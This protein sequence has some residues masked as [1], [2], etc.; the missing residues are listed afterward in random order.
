V[1]DK[2]ESMPRRW[3]SLTPEEWV[4]RAGII[5]KLGGLW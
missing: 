3:N 5:Q 2:L 1:F 4:M